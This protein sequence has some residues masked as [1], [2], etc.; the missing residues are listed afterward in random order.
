MT[1]F[2]PPLYIP[3]PSFGSSV[4][5]YV[6]NLEASVTEQQ[7]L[8]LFSQAVPVVSVRICDDKVTGRSL[9]YAY[10]NF[11]SHEDAKVALEYFNFTVVNGKSI[12]VMFSNRDPTLRRSGAANL[13]IKNLEPNIVA[14][15]LHQMFSRFGIILSCKVATD[16][17]GKSKGYG[18]VQ[19]V[20]EE[21]AK[22]AMNALN[23]KLA[24][25]NGKQLYVDLFI[26]REERQHIGGASKFTNVYTKNLPKE[27]TDDD[28]CRVFAPFGTIT[29]AVVMK[30]GDGE[31]KCF[32]FVNYEK[33]EYAEEAVEKLN[34]KI[35]SDVALYVGRA[36]RKQERQAELKEKFDKERN[37][38]IR[39]SKGCNL[40][41]KNLDCSIDDEYLRNLFGR[42]DDIGT[43]KVMVDSE[44]R[45]KGFGFVLFTT[46]EAANKAAQ[47]ARRHMVGARTPAMPQNI[48][49]RPFYF[50]YGVPGVLV[51]PQA[52][53]FGYQQY[54]QPVI[55]GL[56]PGAPSLMMP[57]HML[58]PIH[59][60]PQQQMA[61][62]PNWNQIVR[63]MPNACNGPTNSAMAPQMDFV[64][65]VVPQISVLTDSVVTAPSISEE[66]SID[67]LA[68]ALAS[69]EPE[70]QH[71]I[72]GERLQPLVAQLEPEHAGKVTEMLLELEKAVVLELIESAENLQEKVNQAMESLRPKKEEGTND[73]AEPSSLSLSARAM[74]PVPFGTCPCDLVG[75]MFN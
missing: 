9:G 74:I 66:P 53:G 13:F 56:N 23:G 59:H 11:H 39:K 50:G 54:P 6:G 26:R 52:T 8:D 72:L 41:L 33:T 34:G 7:L 30:D 45:S 49:P 43:C 20:S 21:S 67:S 35:I 10:V 5:V 71:L 55:P 36:K 58:R 73:P 38:K 22:D 69:A 57:Y 46:I 1:P 16:L 29:S 25:G 27:F 2:G 24:N 61:Q 14:K 64:A 75:L 47:F 37:D 32:G 65:P 63:Y 3:G 4:S 31:S 15:S 18:F 12:R 28:L 48:A 17:N 60:Q 19:F 44:G 62:L 40:Y 68:T 70:K 42:F 51:R